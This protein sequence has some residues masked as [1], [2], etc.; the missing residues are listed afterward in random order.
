MIMGQQFLI[1]DCLSRIMCGRFSRIQG[2]DVILDRFGIKSSPKFEKSYNVA[3]HT[4][5]PVIPQGNSSEIFLKKW[6]M[7]PSW[8]KTEKMN[9]NYINVR[10][11]GIFDNRTTPKLVNHQRCVV[12]ATGF[13]EWKKIGNEKIPSYFQVKDQPVFGFAGLY[14]VWYSDEKSLD[15]FSIIT[16]EPNTIV[17][18]VHNRMP[19]ILQKQN[20]TKWLSGNLSKTDVKNILVPYP[21]NFMSVHQV[22]KRVNSVVNNDESLILPA[23][24]NIID[25]EG[26]RQTTLEDFF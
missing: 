10:A 5:C 18:P 14:S 9:Y 13:Y 6:G 15:S 11:E 17:K 1:F 22:S 21:S 7:V 4:Y 19:V 23:S 3:P 8:S 25:E 20:V 24:S 26:T 12:P 2:M 16:T